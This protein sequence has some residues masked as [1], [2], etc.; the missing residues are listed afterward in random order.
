MVQAVAVTNKLRL[1]IPE[2]PLSPSP[3]ITRLREVFGMSLNSSQSEATAPCQESAS[4]LL[5]AA[6]GERKVS[7]VYLRGEREPE[8]DERLQVMTMTPQQHFGF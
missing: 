3:W 1:R 7:G 2:L 4:S 6:S 5:P 8:T